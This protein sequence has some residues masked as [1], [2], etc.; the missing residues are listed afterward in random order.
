M[1]Q[2]IK[3][4]RRNRETRDWDAYITIE[5]ITQYLGSRANR[6]QA[7]RLVDDFAYELLRRGN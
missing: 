7:E 1:N 2:Y 4:V 6:M 3:D 5:G